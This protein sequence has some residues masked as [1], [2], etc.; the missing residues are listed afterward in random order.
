MSRA[1]RSA[2][3][4]AVLLGLGWYVW[5]FES[6]DRPGDAKAVRMWKA[7]PED[8]VKFELRDVA[9]GL[10]LTCEKQPDG[11]WWITAPT[12]LEADGEQ[13]EQVLKHLAE[14]EVE[15][16]LD[17]LPDLAPFGLSP[18][19]A[20][21]AF[22]LK[23]GG[24]FAA[25]LGG[26]NPTDTAY[27]ALPEGT[28]SPYTVAG[29]SAEHWKKTVADLRQKA[30]VNLDPAQVVKLVIDRPKEPAARQRIELVRDGADAWKLVKP[31]ATGADRYVVEGLLNDLK[32]LR[33][34]TV[35]EEGQAFSRY[36][37]DQ[38][39]VRI[40]IATKTGTGQT[41]TLARPRPGG[42]VYAS[43]TRLPFTMKLGVATLLDGALKGIDDFRER[44][45]L[46]ADKEE[47]TG[48]ALDV[49]GFR[50][51]ATGDGEAWK[52]VEPAGRESAAGTDLTDALFEFIYVRAESFG[53]DAPKSLKP[54]GLAPPRASITLTGVKDK[55]PF[56]HAYA[57][58][59][60]TGDQVWCRFGD[61]Q[62]VVKVRR[63]LL[64]RAERL[65]DKIR[66]AGTEQKPEP[67]KK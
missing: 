12:R 5:K 59:T 20:R 26:K 48:L 45:L 56:T 39:H 2:V 13:I 51:R 30:L 14:P 40:V 52:V 34:D 28:A 21:I 31:V 25:L 18:A 47:L 66:T 36:R 10:S 63:D 17:A 22:T 61:A 4:L 15:R 38:P 49:G 3:T 44:L 67:K 60:R 16:K 33:A 53:D 19:K 58:G 24:T 32:A 46:Q 29:W 7:A 6:G 57:L 11:S 54:F 50:I 41:V 37:L 62:G 1:L 8:V 35:I 55:Q 65:A 64:D 42:D 9:T 27:F 43:S 23:K